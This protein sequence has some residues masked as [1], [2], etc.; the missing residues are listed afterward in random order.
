[1]VVARVL[2]DDAERVAALRDRFDRIEGDLAPHDDAAVGGA[3]E[4]AAAVVDQA[5]ALLRGA[6][7]LVGGEIP[8]AVL[9]AVIDA[10][11]RGLIAAAFALV[12]PLFLELALDIEGG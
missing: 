9:D 6:V 4:L 10:A 2:A 12:G 7:L 11:H 1:D 8:P 5:L 3:E